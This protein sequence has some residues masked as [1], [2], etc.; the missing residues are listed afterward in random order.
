MFRTLRHTVALLFTLCSLQAGA[1]NWPSPEIEQMYQ[2]ARGYLMSGNLQQAIVAYRQAIQ[3]APDQMILHRDLGR[4]YYLSGNVQQAEDILEPI[5]KSG[6]ADEQTYQVMSSIQLGSGDKKKARSTLQKGLDKYPRSGLLYH[7]LGKL[8][9]EQNEMEEALSSWLTGIQQ[10]P[11]YHLNYYEAARAYLMT[12]KPVWTILYGEVFVNIEQQTPRSYE[13]REML[14]NAYKKVYYTVP[15]GDIPKYSKNIKQENTSGFE[16]TVRSAMSKLAPVVS[17]GVN[18][19]NLTMLRTRFAMDW[20]AV[21]SKRYPFSLFAFH[22]K[23]LRMGYFEAYNEWLFGKVE[24]AQQH[25]AWLKFHE[26]A[27]PAFES[28][29]SQNRYRPEANDFYNDKAVSGL[30][31]EK[32][33]SKR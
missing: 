33:D 27:M 6:E 28:W 12:D 26:G 32:K 7:D 31:A 25:E 5:M 1:Q 23:M 22:D 10:D 24:N 13:V 20:S 19:E 4:A 2:A 14:L 3:L 15:S 16:S 18:T 21:Y 9:E 17:D 11:A 8:Y 29:L 30:F